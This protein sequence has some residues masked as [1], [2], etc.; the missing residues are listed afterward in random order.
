MPVTADLIGR[1]FGPGPAVTV[2]AEHLIAFAR[3]V[4][5]HDGPTVDPAAAREAG[6][7]G[8]IAAPTYAIALTLDGAAELSRDPEIGLDFS[9]V[10]HS[11]QRFEYV[12]PIT[13]GDTLT[14]TTTVQ[15]VKSLAGNTVLTVQGDVRDAAGQ[16]VCTAWTTLVIRPVGQEP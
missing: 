5:Y 14:V 13:A 9:H 2:D 10:V 16:S 4:G 1:V 11:D 15:D 7:D 6:F 12:R 8:I 3:A